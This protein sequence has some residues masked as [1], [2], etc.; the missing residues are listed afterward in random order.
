MTTTMSPTRIIAEIGVNHNGSL[1]M[2]LDLIEKAQMLAQTLL[3]FRRFL[4]KGS[5]PEMP[6]KQ[7]IKSSKMVKEASSKCL[8]ALNCLMTIIAL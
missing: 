3:N 8:S 6:Q 4:Q 7:I 2:A 1:E 5:H